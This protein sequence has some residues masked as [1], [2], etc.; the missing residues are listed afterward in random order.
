MALSTPIRIALGL[1]VAT[2]ALAG[3]ALASGQLSP[4][5]A[6]AGPTS[7]TNQITNHVDD[8]EDDD[9]GD[10]HESRTETR[11]IDARTGQVLTEDIRHSKYRSDDAH[12]DDE[13]Q[14]RTDDHGGR[15]HD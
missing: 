13:R 4:T 6:N 8:Q 14:D 1:G 7:L 12:D 5:K 2:L 3:F 11:V 9:R 15:D 10:R